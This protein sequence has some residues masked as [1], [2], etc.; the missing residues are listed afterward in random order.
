MEVK[1]GK[2][3]IFIL[4]PTAVGKTATAI[5]LAK[6]IDSEIISI[7]SRQIYRGLDIG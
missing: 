6:N 7:D 1:S 2:P 4:G 3:V 5:E